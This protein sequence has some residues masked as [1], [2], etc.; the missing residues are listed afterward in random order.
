M[1]LLSGAVFE[2][3]RSRVDAIVVL[4]PGLMT[5]SAS[6]RVVDPTTY[7]QKTISPMVSREG[8]LGDKNGVMMIDKGNSSRV[9][10]SMKGQ[11][12]RE[13]NTALA[14]PPEDAFVMKTIQFRKRSRDVHTGTRE[15]W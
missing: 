4:L 10:I 8:Q 3:L 13:R 7:S 2:R 11:S 6:A 9:L 14:L 15:M 5:T 1:I 12:H